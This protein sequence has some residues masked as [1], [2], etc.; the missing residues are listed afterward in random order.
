MCGASGISFASPNG[1]PLLGQ[2]PSAV[3][4]QSAALAS[5]VTGKLLIIKILS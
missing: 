3:P 1:T 4:L 5:F 2:M